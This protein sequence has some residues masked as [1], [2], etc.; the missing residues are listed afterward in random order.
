VPVVL[1]HDVDARTLSQLRAELSAD[2]ELVPVGPADAPPRGDVQILVVGEPLAE[3][4]A[5]VESLVQAAPDVPLLV[6]APLGRMDLAVRAM[7]AGAW[8]VL[9]DPVDARLLA[10]TVQRALEHKRL[11]RELASLRG[12]R[13]ARGVGDLIGESPAMQRVFR[14]IERM[15]VA[16]SSVLITGESGTGKELVARALHQLSPRSNGPFV[17][18]NCAALPE[19]LLESELFGHVRGAFTDARTHREGLFSQARGGTLMLDEIGDLPAALQPKLLRVLQERKVRP[20]GGDR[21]IPLDVRIIAATHQDLDALSER[22]DFRSDLLFRL[23]VLRLDLPP[24]R[25]RGQDVLLLASRLLTGHAESMGRPTPRIG[26]DVAR[27]LLA[28]RWPGNVRELQNAMER[29]AAL[30]DGDEL[31]LHDLPPRISS[32]ARAS[33]TAASPATL[34][35]L[36]AATELLPLAE[37]ERRHIQT[38][39]QATGGNRAHAAR[40][41]GLDRKTLWRKLRAW[42][43]ADHD[44]DAIDEPEPR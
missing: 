14:L 3:P 30:C 12:A 29:A 22:G 43:H 44:S 20:V 23:D 10:L 4:A 18:I 40:I 37:V 7:R 6:I 19:A 2:T 31:H 32:A 35:P 15:A 28:Y 5:R 25:E 17:A 39:L 27:A 16:P 26:P 21:E 36:P 38:V 34:A 24:L 9:P 33:Q 13:R 11:R 42:A 8:D 1:L 41:L